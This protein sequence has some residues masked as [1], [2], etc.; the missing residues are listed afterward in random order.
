M[1]LSY[2]FYICYVFGKITGF[3]KILKYQKCFFLQTNDYD[4]FSNNNAFLLQ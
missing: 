3:E 1:T 4:H 2:N